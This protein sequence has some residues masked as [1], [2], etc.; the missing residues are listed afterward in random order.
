MKSIDNSLLSSLI[1]LSCITTCV[2]AGWLTR[3]QTIHIINNFGDDS[4]PLIFRCQSG[5][6][7]LGVRSLAK[8]QE[9][10][11]SFESQFFLRT[12]FF[13]RFKR[14][15]VFNRSFDLYKDRLDIHLC[16]YDD[17][18]YTNYY[19]QARKDGIFFSCNGVD[20]HKRCDWDQRI[21]CSH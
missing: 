11:F 20:Y 2:M 14:G 19:W 10:H 3:E 15:H 6:D 8:G 16:K 9:F 13:C 12:L 21:P 17:S 7:D 4:V 1:M 18:K 5:D